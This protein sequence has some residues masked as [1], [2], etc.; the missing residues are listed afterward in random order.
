MHPLA[1]IYKA[2]AALLSSAACLTVVL[3]ASPP[4]PLT[5]LRSIAVLS[6]SAA[7]QSPQAVFEGVVTHARSA[8]GE[9]FVQQNGWGRY[10]EDPANTPVEPGDRVRI[11]GTVVCDARPY[12]HAVHID[13]LGRGP[14]PAPSPVRFDELLQGHRDDV[15]VRIRGQ[16]RSA[17]ANADHRGATVH[18]QTD[19]GAIDALIF[20]TDG[21]LLNSL[22]DA[23]VD[24]TGI[25]GARMD[26]KNQRT[27]AILYVG[28][29]GNFHILHRASTDPWLLPATPMDSIVSAYHVH[30]L[31]R[32]VRVHG[33]VTYVEPGQTAV[34]Q[35]GERS[36]W[37]GTENRDP[38]HVG[39][40]AD[41]IGFPRITGGLL[42]LTQAEIRS[43]GARA[44]I[45][46]LSLGW[47][48]LA[49]GR[50]IFDLVSTEGTVVMQVGGPTQDEYVLSADGY[51][52][53]AIYRHPLDASAHH[54]EP[55][56]K[57][58][59][60]S[61]VRATGI[62]VQD[63]ADPGDSRIPFNLLLRSPGDIQIL[64][65]P[66]LLTIRNMV[67]SVLIL[68]LLLVG[69]S[70]RFWSVERKVRREMATVAYSERR[71]SRILEEI[72][73]S[74]PL[75]E[76]VEQTTELVSF[77]LQ[78]APCWVQIAGGACLGSKPSNSGGLRIHELPIP[79]HSG[80]PL[81]LISAAFDPHV[82]YKLGEGEALSMAAGLITLA[83]ETR[84]A[85]SDLVRRSE[86]DLLTDVQNRF[87]F[88]RRV[89]AQIKFA[90]QSASIFG[91]IYIDLN[92]F[93]QVNDVYG[94]QFGDF[95][96]QEVARRMKRQ[97]RPSDVLARLGGDEFAVLVCE[98][99]SRA[100][101]DEIAQRLEH[102][103]DDPFQVAGSVV[104]GSAALGVAMYPQDARTRDSLIGA[105][106]YAMY[107]V[108]NTRSKTK[109]E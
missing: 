104:R 40:V 53:S 48:G 103:Y 85:Y 61:R 80:P 10:I 15:L 13:R 81:G 19:G 71:R 17:D 96:L 39:D 91:I 59:I 11:H 9:L 18:L 50:H 100:Q 67:L 62:C 47:A 34:L 31:S 30:N 56:R 70:A 2:L 44:S 21:R 93:K 65:G 3:Y 23:E 73:G 84:K 37:I 97:L 46:P 77:R 4:E 74:T 45:A 75:A 29:L 49:A 1:A 101:V 26:G 99:G 109:S 87:S 98:V 69:V 94:H 8:Q 7:C 6:R 58:P 83:I 33:V 78:G 106:D 63:T 68:A 89:E 51:V 64:R 22:L 43:T 38:L 105:A 102:C 86:V 20:N 36:L 28:S 108:K 42:Q 55:L 5:D 92:D 14:V 16:V 52:F 88:E 107:D 24:V 57:L 79:A 35:D 95:Y 32:R 12:V 76:I 27:G 90:R 60:G 41:A 82:D 54:L 66:S 25:A 72:N